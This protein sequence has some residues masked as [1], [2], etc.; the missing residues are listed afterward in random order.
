VI[1]GAAEHFQRM[2]GIL[3]LVELLGFHVHRDKGEAGGRSVRQTHTRFTNSLA[4]LP[5]AVFLA[6]SAI[7]SAAVELSAGTIR[8][9]QG[10]KTTKPVHA[11]VHVTLSRET[12]EML[13]GTMPLPSAAVT[14]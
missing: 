11:T 5:F 7:T 9:N 8:S 4:S 10:V 13:T 3:E 1:N 14:R 6:A 12:R 2:V